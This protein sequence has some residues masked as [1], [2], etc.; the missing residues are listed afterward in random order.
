MRSLCHELS[1][2]DLTLYRKLY[3]VVG[4]ILDRLY[5]Q[6]LEYEDPLPSRDVITRIFEI[7]GSMLDWEQSVPSTLPTI[8]GSQLAESLQEHVITAIAEQ[9]LKLRTILTLR[10]MNTRLLLHR[11]VLLRMLKN[12]SG[13]NNITSD[14]ALLEQFGANSISAS[15]LNAT[16]IIELVRMATTS[17]LAAG[18][19]VLGAWWFTLYYSTCCLAPST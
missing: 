13:S 11:P 8:S 9:R 7:E 16:E 15:L 18:K 12:M 14:N 6:N 19:D 5:G 3:N 17:P 2:L 10:F 1:L 4:V